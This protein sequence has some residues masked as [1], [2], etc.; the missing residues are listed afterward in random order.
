MTPADIQRMKDLL[1]TTLGSAEIRERLAAD[2]LRR[3]VFSA[4]MA[5]APY[6]AKVRDVCAALSAGTIN[7]ADARSQLLPILS[8]MGYDL[9]GNPTDVK[10]PASERRLNLILDTQR[11]MAASVSLL[12][13]QDEGTV[14]QFPGWELCRMGSR[15]MPRK[16]WLARWQYAGRSVGWQGAVDHPIYG[17]ANAF[18]FLALKSSPIWQA[19]GDGAGGF[20]DT[21][22][23]PYPPF[24][25]GSGMAW[26]DADRET[27]ERYGLVGDASG[28]E[29]SPRPTDAVSQS[30]PSLS[31]GEADILDAVDRYG[32]DLS[33]GLDL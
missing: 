16:D 4:R 7:Q 19:I 2:I 23:N 28:A 22:R 1:P 21:L 11:Q 14:A 25:Y 8:Q 29:R 12:V 31:P 30:P 10:D 15:A 24:A 6:L 3:S 18:G 13:R 27:C 5:S 17:D 33:E 32:F 9:Q 26:Q 20:N